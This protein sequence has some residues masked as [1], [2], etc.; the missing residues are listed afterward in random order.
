MTCLKSIRLELACWVI[1][2]WMGCFPLLRLWCSVAT[3]VTLL[4]FFL[5]AMRFTD[6]WFSSFLLVKI[7]R[8]R[9]NL[10]NFMQ[11]NHAARVALTPKCHGVQSHH[12]ALLPFRVR[13]RRLH[14]VR[15]SRERIVSC[16]RHFSTSRI[17]EMDT[18][19][20]VS[21]RNGDTIMMTK[22]LFFSR[23]WKEI[24]S[25]SDEIEYIKKLFQIRHF[26]SQRQTHWRRTVGRWARGGGTTTDPPWW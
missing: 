4:P 26:S 11:E 15:N 18:G 9:R 8:S 25:S 21:T 7:A 20:N 17:L 23:E 22:N 19:N 6:G 12:R 14:Q 2:A 1:L 3:G 10:K 13:R 16:L 5:R 24:G